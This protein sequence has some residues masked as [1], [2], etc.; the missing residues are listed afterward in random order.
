MTESGPV[1]RQYRAKRTRARMLLPAIGGASHGL[2]S[3]LGAH[4]NRLGSRVSASICRIFS[5]A[6]NGTV[7]SRRG[8]SWQ[9]VLCHRGRCPKVLFHPFWASRHDLCQTPITRNQSQP[10]TFVLAI[11]STRAERG[12][13]HMHVPFLASRTRVQLGWPWGPRAS[14][15]AIHARSTA[16]RTEGKLLSEP[17]SLRFP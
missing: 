3:F 6:R 5:R 16:N 7:P 14:P 1:Q 15:S 10:G 13:R 9:Q 8:R 12:G 2:W 4:T 11:D 17:A